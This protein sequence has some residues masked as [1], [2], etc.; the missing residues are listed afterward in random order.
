[1]YTTT[2]AAQREKTRAHQPPQLAKTHGRW[3]KKP[4]KPYMKVIK[5]AKNNGRWP[6]KPKF[7]RPSPVGVEEWPSQC[8]E[9]IVSQ[10]LFFLFFVGHLPWFVASFI[11]FRYG[12]ICFFGHLPCVFANC[13]GWWARCLAGW[14]CWAGC[15]AG[16]P[17]LLAGWPSNPPAHG[18]GSSPSH[19][20]VIIV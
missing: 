13:G 7:G 17:A 1:M 19:Y 10:T 4:I 3:P 8:P 18:L 9:A 11:T 5:L 12:F 16:W 20:L 2:L 6:K 15:L 14:A